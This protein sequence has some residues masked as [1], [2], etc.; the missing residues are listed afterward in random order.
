VVPAPAGYVSAVRAICRKYDVLLIADEV[1]CGAGR[2]G[3]W[4]ALE[5]DGAVPDIMAIAK[6]L[7]GGY[8]PLGATLLTAAVAEPILE[9]HGAYMTGHT[10]SGHTA[11]CAAALAVQKIIERDGLLERVRLAGAALQESLRGALSRFE[12]IGDVRGRGYFIGIELVRDRQTRAPFAADRGLS[13]D[14]AQR[15]FADG[16]ICYPCTGN[17]DGAAGDTIILAPPYNATDAELEEITWR[18]ARAV[19]AALNPR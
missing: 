7:A 6:G 14:I 15:A 5:H 9:E 13:F 10:F 17:V 11:A 4:R 18:L 1:M 12:E 8:I 19:D 3:T 16:L 2:C